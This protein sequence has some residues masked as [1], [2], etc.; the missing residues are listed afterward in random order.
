MNV[1]FGQVYIEPGVSFPFSHD[2][3]RRLSKEVTALVQPSAL[4]IE[5]YGADF[6]LMFNVSAKQRLKENEIRGP[7]VFKKT[8]NVEYTVFLP[9]EPIIQQSDPPKAALRFLLRGVCDVFDRLEIDKLRLIEKQESLM[10]DIC[11]DL[12]MLEK[13]SWDEAENQTLVRTL[14]TASFQSRQKT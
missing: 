3:Q 1:W 6:E 12:S 10:D 11:S 4:F 13:P 5:T 14:F 9:F 2:F 8:K 7:S